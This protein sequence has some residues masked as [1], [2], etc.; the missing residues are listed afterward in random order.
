MKYIIGQ[1]APGGGFILSPADEALPATPKANI[2]AFIKAAK[3]WSS[4]PI[5]I[6]LTRT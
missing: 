1:A 2:D 6:E 4:Y 3:K 5:P